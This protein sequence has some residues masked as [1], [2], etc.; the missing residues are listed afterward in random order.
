VDVAVFKE[1]K[2]AVEAAGATVEVIAPRIGGVVDNGGDMIP[3]QQK[4]GGGPSVLYDAVALLLSEDGAGTIASEAAARDFVND[5]FAHC[6]FIAYTPEALPLFES[7]GI[8]SLL[9]AGC[10]ELGKAKSIDKFVK[11]C[12]QLRL[13]EREDMVNKG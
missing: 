4:L 7:A 12:K 1:L 9:D 10:F 5:A 3:A 11:A 2:D 8:A 13:W 6:K